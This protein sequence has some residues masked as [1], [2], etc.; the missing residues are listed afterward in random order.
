MEGGKFLTGV[1]VAPSPW[2]QTASLA[3]THLRPLGRSITRSTEGGPY[4][5]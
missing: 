5:V 4:P 1:M 3:D 2:R